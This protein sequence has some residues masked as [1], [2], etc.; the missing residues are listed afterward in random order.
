MSVFKVDVIDEAYVAQK[1]FLNLLIFDHLDWENARKHAR[2]LFEKIKSYIYFIESE[3]YLEHTKGFD[4]ETIIVRCVFR[5]KPNE[6]GIKFL[7]SINRFF[8]K[9]HVKRGIKV[10][11]LL[12]FSSVHCCIIEKLCIFFKRMLKIW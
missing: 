5:E 9:I 12:D 6:L 11:F 4:V 10:L 7:A 3:Q 1:N 2:V 8:E